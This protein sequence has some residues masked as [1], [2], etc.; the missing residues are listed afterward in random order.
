MDTK[1]G[2]A[3]IVTPRS[4]TFLLPANVGDAQG[5]V[6]SLN[7][8]KTVSVTFVASLGNQPLAKANRMLVLYLTDLKNS[9]TVIEHEG[10]DSIILREY[11]ELPILMR[12]GRVTMNFRIPG[13]PL[14]KVWALKYDG[15][16][17]REIIPTA[18]TDGF[19]FSASAFTTP[20]V[21]S[22]YEVAWEQ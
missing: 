6:L 1:A 14:P 15:T 22:A 9:G 13:R 19:S 4:E 8:N 21:F 20:E 10:N 2:T 17:A 12:Q 16:R 5:N 11:G 7:G 18:S 3:L